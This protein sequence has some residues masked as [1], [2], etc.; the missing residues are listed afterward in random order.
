MSAA[1][2]AASTA[3]SAA[4]SAASAT[5]T[6]SAAVAA[7]STVSAF[8][9]LYVFAELVR[10]GI[11][12]VEDIERRQA[13]VGDFLFAESNFVTRYGGLQWY[14]CCRRGCGGCAACHRQR[15]TGKSRHR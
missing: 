9:Q 10:S 4:V 5:S 1:S 3:V 7:V 15:H 12:L 14:I 8:C 13:D 2:A 11:F 6:A